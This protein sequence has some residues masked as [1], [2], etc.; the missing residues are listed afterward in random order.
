MN[1]KKISLYYHFLLSTVSAPEEDGRKVET[2]GSQHKKHK[3][4]IEFSPLVRMPVIY[5]RLEYVIPYNCE[6]IIWF[7]LRAYQPLLVI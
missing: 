7:G 2:L 5:I 1:K 3:E 4:E 6:Q